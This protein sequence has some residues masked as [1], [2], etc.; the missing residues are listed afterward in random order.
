[1]K[2]YGSL[3]ESNST[4][5]S[6]RK[7][8]FPPVLVIQL[9]HNGDGGI[10]VSAVLSETEILLNDEE[11]PFVF[12]EIV[13]NEDMSKS[14]E[15]SLQQRVCFS[16]KHIFV[17]MTTEEFLAADLKSILDKSKHG[18]AILYYLSY[19]LEIKQKSVENFLVMLTTEL[20]SSKTKDVARTAER[21]LLYELH[22]V[23]KIKNLCRELQ[24]YI[25][26]IT[27]TVQGSCPITN[28]MVD[29]GL[30]PQDIVLVQNIFRDYYQKTRC[31]IVQYELERALMV[32]RF[33]LGFVKNW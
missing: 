3:L 14:L 12:G 6:Y 10:Y 25:L 21:Q 7:I 30:F 5:S 24:G 23:D 18:R 28:T 33:E 22:Y 4:Y 31:A 8:P 19:Y 29:E 32:G 15:K 9:S 13:L 16:T 11:K 27:E 1:M 2:Q 26:S 17:Y 20:K